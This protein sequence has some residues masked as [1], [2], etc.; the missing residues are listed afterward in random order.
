MARDCSSF[1]ALCGIWMIFFYFCLLICFVESILTVKLSLQRLNSSICHLIRCFPG[2]TTSHRTFTERFF[3]HASCW[4][5]VVL[6]CWTV[7]IRKLGVH[8]RHNATTQELICL[9]HPGYNAEFDRFLLLLHSETPKRRFEIG[10][11]ESRKDST[12]SS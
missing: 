8:S 2:D 5:S 11:F 4:W 10:N 9:P 6:L 7:A 12:M 1:F 3:E